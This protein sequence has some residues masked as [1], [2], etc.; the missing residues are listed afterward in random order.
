MIALV[1]GREPAEDAERDR[2]QHP[3]GRPDDHLPVATVTMQP[4]AIYSKLI[5]PG[6]PTRSR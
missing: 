3:A 1:E 5:N 4:L 6:V 2:A